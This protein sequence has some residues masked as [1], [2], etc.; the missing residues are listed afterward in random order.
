MSRSGKIRSTIGP[1]I[2][3]LR[4][5]MEIAKTLLDIKDK[6]ED[7]LTM[8]RQEQVRLTTTL[9]RLDTLHNEWQAYIDTLEDEALEAENAI[10]DNFKMDDLHFAEYIEEGK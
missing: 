4:D 3:Y 8:I 9:T 1:A 5:R 7:T 10:Y 2:K 6:K